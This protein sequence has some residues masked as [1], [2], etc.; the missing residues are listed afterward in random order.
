MKW[1]WVLFAGI[2]LVAVL[3]IGLAAWSG[4]D[5]D[6]E[7]VSL[8]QVPPAVKATILKAA[9]GGTITEIEVETENGQTV[10]EAEVIIDG[11]EVDILVA[12][13]GALLG[14]EVE[15][16]EE[17]DEEEVEVEADDDDDEE[18]EEELVALEDVPAAVKA[19][20]LKEAGD[21]TI[22]EIERET[23][24]GQVVY[25]AEVVIDGEEVDIEV[26]AD[27]TLLGKEVE[28]DEEEDEEEVEADDDEG[29]EELVALA[30][31]PAAV[32]ATILKE[33]GD[34]TITEIE[35]ETENGQK[36]Y[37]AE[38]VIDGKEVDIEVAADGKLL[39]KEADDEED[40][41]S[42]DDD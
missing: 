8:D 32:K 42:D 6:E 31:L 11:K 12:P 22:E 40:E 33:A 25:E 19:T 7:Q 13:D 39:G 10:Y 28:G 23:E 29:D 1:H 4:G 2:A 9:E 17:E 37:E 21:G 15:G 24:N 41:D 5:D 38:V 14:K 35:V 18:G 34:G 30:D 16:D 20:I 27:G 26:A 36:V 3:A